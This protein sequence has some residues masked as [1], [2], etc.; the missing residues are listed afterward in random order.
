MADAHPSPQIFICYAHKD[1]DSSD[2]SKR[3]LDRL[4]EHLGPFEYQE[5]LAIWS[6]QRIEIGSTWHDEIQSTLHSA[7]VAILLISPSFLNSKYIR[8][9]ELPV[10]LQRAKEEQALS[11]LPV[12]LRPCALDEVIFKYPDPKSGPQTLSLSSLQAA[13]TL[14]KPL[15][16]LSE[17]I[18]D[19]LKRWSKSQVISWERS[20]IKFG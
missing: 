10:L 4:L 7:R 19:R 5:E 15:N 1:N 18:C 16:G 20:Q 17:V 6:D 3:W 8:N 2:S 11:I 13:N 9:S 14:N 12:I